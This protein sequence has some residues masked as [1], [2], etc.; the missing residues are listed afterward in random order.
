MK[1]LLIGFRERFNGFAQFITGFSEYLRNALREKKIET[2][3]E[4]RSGET[5]I[6]TGICDLGETPEFYRR[7]AGTLCDTAQPQ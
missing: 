2:G 4:R 7:G 5:G 1:S 3:Q 6:I